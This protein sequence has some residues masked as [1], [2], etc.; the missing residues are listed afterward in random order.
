MKKTLYLLMASIMALAMVS[1]GE[2]DTGKN[3]TDGAISITSE[4]APIESAQESASPNPNE[5]TASPD[6]MDLDNY[7]VKVLGVITGIKDYEGKDA[8]GIKYEFTNNGDEAESAS[9]AIYTAAYQ[10]GIEMDYTYL[11]EETAPEE[12]LNRDKNIK[13]GVTLVCAEYFS[14]DGTKA[15]VEF[16]LRAAFSMSNAKIQKT[17]SIS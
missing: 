17:Y 1:C 14:T 16:E 8:V 4:A 15:D 5:P 2:N 13:P 11:D 12:C 10:N 3:N 9:T 6:E 7:H